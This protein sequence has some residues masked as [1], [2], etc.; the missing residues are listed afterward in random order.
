MANAL[1]QAIGVQASHPGRQVITLSGDGG[2]AM[3]LGD[4][5]TLRQLKLP[6]KLVVFNNS[7][8]GF[9][10]LEMKA[11]GLVDYGTDLVNPNFA[12]LAESA[13]VFG[14]RVEKPEELRPALTEALAH[15]GPA[16]V[17][18]VVN[19]QELSMPPTISLDQALGFG[20]YMIRALLS[21]RGDEVIDLAKTNLMR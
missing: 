2:L 6:V 7:S 18:V 8:L 15:D 10:E 17:E 1:P 5:L 13:D 11:A 3:L 16:L 21:G 4:L 20:L 12:K 9:V 14:V 19:R